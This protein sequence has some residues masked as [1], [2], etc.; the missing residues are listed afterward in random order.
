L[1]YRLVLDARYV[2]SCFGASKTTGIRNH[3]FRN[4]YVC[5]VEIVHQKIVI[6]TLSH[7]KKQ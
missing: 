4:V 7:P 6:F 1:S 2:N 3:W 5:F